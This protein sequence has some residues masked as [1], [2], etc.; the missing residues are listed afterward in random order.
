MYEEK[1]QVDHV[2]KLVKMNILFNKILECKANP[3]SLEVD[4]LLTEI[5]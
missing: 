2:K 3:K 4:M 5:I 1:L